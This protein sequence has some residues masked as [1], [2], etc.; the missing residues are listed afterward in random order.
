MIRFKFDQRKPEDGDSIITFS[1]WVPT[2]LN[3]TFLFFSNAQNLERI[4]PPFLKFRILTPSP[5]E[6]R[7]GALIDYQLKLRGFPIKWRTEITEWEPQKGFTDI[8]IRGPYQKWVHRHQFAA[9]NG[10]TLVTD[11]IHYLV[12]GGSLVNRLFVKPDLDKV[13]GYRREIIAQLLGPPQP[14]SPE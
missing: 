5:I 12:P 14:N 10:G 1:Q 6:M 8:Q 4:T 11:T 13:F 2:P 9:D 7:V 3:E